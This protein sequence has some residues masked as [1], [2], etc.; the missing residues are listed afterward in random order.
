MIATLI[1]IAAFDSAVIAGLGALSRLVVERITAE[2]TSVRSDNKEES[3]VLAAFH[4]S[5]VH[6]VL[7]KVAFFIAAEKWSARPKFR[8]ILVGLAC[9]MSWL[10]C[11]DSL[12]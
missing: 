12:C 8:I 11:R 2:N 9:G 4:D 3:H 1:A 7:S 6:T 5:L 10:G